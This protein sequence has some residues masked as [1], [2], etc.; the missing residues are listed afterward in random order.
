MSESTTGA[1][2]GVVVPAF[3]GARFIAATIASVRAQTHAN[4]V[5]VVVDDGSDDETAMIARDAIDGDTR[6]KVIEQPNQGP[7]VARNIGYARLGEAA[8]LITFMDADDVWLPDALETLVRA[9]AD[10]PNAVG[11]HG[12]GDFIDEH[13]RWI[14]PGAFAGIGRRRVDPGRGWPRVR[15]PGEPTTF[16]TVATTSG[17]FPPGLILARRSAYEKA[18]LFDPNARYAEDWDMLIR[19]A[20]HGDLV[21]VDRVILGYRRHSSNVGASAQVPEACARVRRW[22]FTDPSA[23]P[24][25]ERALR[26]SWRAAQVLGVRQRARSGLGSLRQRR[27]GLASRD[28]ARLPLFVARYGIGRPV[29][30]AY[31]PAPPPEATNGW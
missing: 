18:G 16:A 3:R 26:S 22:T 31:R 14:D 8:S 9:L 17:I 11:A 13:G 28:L 6:F 30:R 10:Q 25:Q 5:G 21:A 20:R 12:L 24:A 2:V 19:L 4:L 29:P 23:D 7:C 1:Q 27:I 15:A